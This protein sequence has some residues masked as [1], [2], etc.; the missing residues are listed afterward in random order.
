M[1]TSNETKLSLSLGGA[2]SVSSHGVTGSSKRASPP[3]NH[4]PTPVQQILPAKL[5]LG[6]VSSTVGGA[7]VKDS[8]QPQMKTGN[9]ETSCGGGGDGGGDTMFKQQAPVSTHD[10]RTVSMSTKTI[11]HPSIARLSSPSSLPPS[12]PSSS[13]GYLPA[14]LAASLSVH[15]TSNIMPWKLRERPAGSRLGSSSAP[16]C[17]AATTDSPLRGSSSPIIASRYIVQTPQE[18]GSTES[19]SSLSG[20]PVYPPTIAVLTLTG[21]DVVSQQSKQNIS[22]VK[23]KTEIIYL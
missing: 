19:S 17:S 8:R 18:N 6:G 3:S 14:A 2:A 5:S 4:T 9:P 10:S 13:T 22:P 11:Q 20:V 12:S 7:R 15:T 21:S 16:P 1:S 23:K